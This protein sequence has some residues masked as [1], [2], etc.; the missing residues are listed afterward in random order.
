M[1][2]SVEI[3]RTE[4]SDFDKRFNRIYAQERASYSSGL[5]GPLLAQV[6]TVL[7]T[8]PDGNEKKCLTCQRS[9]G[10]HSYVAWKC[11]NPVY[12]EVGG[13]MYLTSRFEDSYTIADKMAEVE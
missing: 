7:L 10:E 12:G 3:I 5:I 9:L 2:D 11:P 6:D 1:F 4:N 13:E 8:L